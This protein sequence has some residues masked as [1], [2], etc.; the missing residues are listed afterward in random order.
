MRPPGVVNVIQSLIA[1]LAQDRLSKHCWRKDCTSMNG[2][3][4]P[5]YC[6]AAGNAV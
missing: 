6:S 2:S 4:I 3:A 5:S 1:W